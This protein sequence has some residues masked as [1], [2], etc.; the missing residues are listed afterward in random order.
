MQWIKAWKYPPEAQLPRVVTSNTS[1]CINLMID[2]YTSEGWTDLLE[3]VLWKMAEK[4]GVCLRS[5]TSRSYWRYIGDCV[6]C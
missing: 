5:S 6:L 3:G 1:E 2:D 4:I